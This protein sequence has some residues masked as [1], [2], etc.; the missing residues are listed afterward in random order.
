M[1]SSTVSSSYYAGLST[2]GAVPIKN[3]KGEVTM[4]KV[5]VHRYVSGRR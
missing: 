1:S 5:K 4:Q 2:A 3:E